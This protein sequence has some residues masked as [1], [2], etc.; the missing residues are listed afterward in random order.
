MTS[1]HYLPYLTANAAAVAAQ[2][3]IVSY[4]VDG[5]D[6]RVP[7][8]PYRAQCLI[9]LQKR[10]A[11][12]TPIERSSL[13]HFLGKGAGILAAPPQASVSPPHGKGST[14]VDRHWNG[15]NRS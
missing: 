6:W 3:K 7:A 15:R 10:F 4:E 5:L 12:L 1:L 9:A 14:P 2:K 8:S 11:A 13:Q